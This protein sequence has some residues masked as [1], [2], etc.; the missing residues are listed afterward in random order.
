MRM[1]KK[2]RRSFD[3]I[4]PDAWGRIQGEL[5][6][7]QKKTADRGI[8]MSVQKK[9]PLWEA[10]S[11]AAALAMAVVLLGGGLWMYLTYGPLRPSNPDPGLSSRPTESTPVPT[12]PSTEPTQPPTEP[13]TQ[14]PTEPSTDQSAT[15]DPAQKPTFILND[16]GW[17]I[18]LDYGDRIEPV[19]CRYI[20]IIVDGP[21]SFYDLLNHIDIQTVD[22]QPVIR[23]DQWHQNYLYV[24]DNSGPTSTSVGSIWQSGVEA[25]QYDMKNGEF[26][27]TVNAEIDSIRVEYSN[28]GYYE[29]VLTYTPTGATSVTITVSNYDSKIVQCIQTVVTN[30]VETT[31]PLNPSQLPQDELFDY[32]NPNPNK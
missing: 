15:T 29:S 18:A 32:K 11:T 23:G 7:Q 13:P 17:I 2:L 27:F 31:E 28:A 14:P 3:H 24:G 16:R 20:A 4:A 5:P 25:V 12:E 1:K 8:T 21:E 30:G 9:S 26:I 6:Q 22:G 19:D 10:L